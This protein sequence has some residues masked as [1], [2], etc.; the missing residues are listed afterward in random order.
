MSAVAMLAVLTVCGAVALGYALGREQAPNEHDAEATEQDAFA[1]AFADARDSSEAR[2][3]RQGAI[4]GISAGRRAGSRR[5]SALAARRADEDVEEEL[6]ASEP[7]AEEATVATEP[8]CSLP[9]PGA[10]YCLTPEEAATEAE[11]EEGGLG[12]P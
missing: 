8:V 9:Y 11:A 3:A 2:S 5:G 4:E 12:P 1:I 10:P 7:I 6:S